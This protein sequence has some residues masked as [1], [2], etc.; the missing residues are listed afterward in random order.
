MLVLLSVFV[1][2]G[3]GGGVGVYAC[4]FVCMKF[5]YVLCV[6][7]CK[8]LELFKVGC[9]EMLISIINKKDVPLV[10][11][12]YLVFTRM[13]GESYH[14]QLGSLLCYIF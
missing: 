12:M 4:M 13:P 11:F 5:M 3:G 6:K 1:E 8:H 7:I 10:E 14:R 2:V 9:A